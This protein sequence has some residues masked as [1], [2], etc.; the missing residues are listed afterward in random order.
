M[1][2]KALLYIICVPLVLYALQSINYEKFLKSNKINQA[3]ILFLMLSLGISY[4]CVNFFYDFF[5]N[6]RIM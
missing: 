2:I 3:R 5:I 6:T 1:S 4:L